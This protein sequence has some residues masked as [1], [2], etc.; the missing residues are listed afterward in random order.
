MS[1]PKSRSKYPAA[2]PRNRAA[3]ENAAL[4]A[5]RAL[6]DNMRT[7]YRQLE[8]MTDA[9]IS[10]HRALLC[11]GNTPG[12]PA[13]QLATQLGMQR[14]A[15]SHVLKN[16]AARG[17]IERRRSAGDQRSVQV[18]ATADGQ[19]IL[20][21]TA[22]RAVGTLQRA[23]RSLSLRELDQ[24]AQGVGALLARLPEGPPSRPASKVRRAPFRGAERAARLPAR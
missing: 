9:P 7:L 11:I 4:L 24:L 17:W 10:M 19:Q 13:S 14:P 20:K 16:L 23:V 15:V 2:R 22:G 3:L 18:H 1:P 6:V 21:A 8:R 5:A 12:V